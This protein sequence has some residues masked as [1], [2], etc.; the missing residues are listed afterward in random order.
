MAFNNPYTQIDFNQFIKQFD[1]SFIEMMNMRQ[2]AIDEQCFLELKAALEK[3]EC[4]ICKKSLKHIDEDNPCYHWLIN[5]DVRKKKY[6]K[7]FDG[8]L[9]LLQMYGYL[10]WVANTEKIFTNIDDTSIGND[11]NK[12]FETTIRYKQFEWTFSLA[13]TDL[14]GHKG[15]ESDFLHFHFQMKKDGNIIIKFNDFHIP[16]SQYDFQMIK[17][18]KQGVMEYIPSFE[19]GINTLDT[20]S[21]E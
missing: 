2:Q 17:M 5:P 12:I 19:A 4:S 13:K 1:P 16:L 20:L 11:P 10:T 6:K 14:D 7:L 21:L 9:G 3:G 18:K 8:R 15:T